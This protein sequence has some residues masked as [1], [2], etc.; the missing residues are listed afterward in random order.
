MSTVLEQLFRWVLAS[1]VKGA[2]LV[3]IILLIKSLVRNKLGANWHYA[4][5]VLLFLQLV[6]PWTPTSPLSIYKLMPTNVVESVMHSDLR[7]VSDAEFSNQT[8]S[9]ES[10][11]ADMASEPSPAKT[12]SSHAEYTG[13]IR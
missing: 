9:A 10:E 2:V 12:G 4:I 11:I 8:V 7:T 1:S 3:A 5:W 13:D 6:L